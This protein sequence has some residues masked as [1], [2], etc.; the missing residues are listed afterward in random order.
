MILFIKQ[1]QKHRFTKLSSGD[2]KGKEGW[3]GQIGGLGLT[4]THYFIQNR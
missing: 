4:Y 2:Q 1:K 3:E